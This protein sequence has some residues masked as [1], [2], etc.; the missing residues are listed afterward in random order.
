MLQNGDY[1]PYL[2]QR[3][4]SN[5]W[6]LDNETA[7]SFLQRLM[8][9]DLQHVVLAHLSEENNDPAIA[10]KAA[11]AALFD[12]YNSRYMELG[13]SV[14]GQYAAGELICLSK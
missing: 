14:A 6:Q 7:S 3:I 9:D 12:P 1:P 13:I 8:H 2:K 11:E 5:H 4:R 10:Y